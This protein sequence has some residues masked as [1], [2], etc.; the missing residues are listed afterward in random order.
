MNDR[1]DEILRSLVPWGGCFTKVLKQG[2]F[3]YCAKFKKEKRVINS[4]PN[5]GHCI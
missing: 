1:R 2:S 5:G 4:C 3:P